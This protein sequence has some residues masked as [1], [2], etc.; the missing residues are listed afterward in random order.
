MLLRL[1]GLYMIDLVCDARAQPFYES[2]GMQPAIGM[3]R[4]NYER[5]SGRRPDDAPTGDT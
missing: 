1:D 5:Q 4:R 2:A 3:M